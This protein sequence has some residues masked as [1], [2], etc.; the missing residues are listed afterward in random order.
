MQTILIKN[1]EK[2]QQ[3]LYLAE[4][5]EIR[6][7]FWQEHLWKCSY[8]LLLIASAQQRFFCKL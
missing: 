7:L 6:L 2:K 5:L 3:Q 8:C 4:I 1:L